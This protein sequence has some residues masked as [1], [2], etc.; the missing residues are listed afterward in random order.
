MNQV[1]NYFR[2]VPWG[3]PQMI[4]MLALTFLFIP[5]FIESLLQPYLIQ[6]FG[7]PLYGGTLTG[8]LMAIVFLSG[9]YLA[10]LQPNHL[11]WKEVGLR[12]FD[13]RYRIAIVGWIMTLIVVSIVVVVGMESLFGMGT[14]NS[15]T[16]SLQN[17]LSFSAIWI[18]FL[19]ATVV[20]PIYEEIIYRGFFYRFLRVHFGRNTGLIGSATIFMLVH[21]P[22]YNTLPINF[23]SGLIFAWTYEKTGSILPAIVIHSIFNGIAVLLA[24][25]G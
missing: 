20:S 17:Q 13:Q 11:S 21:I 6:L 2:T 18:A 15:K 1:Q 25:V 10:V 23:I 14:D 8:L 16:D 5:L 7:S 19:S 22:T 24:A 9:L 4:G 12:S 3:W